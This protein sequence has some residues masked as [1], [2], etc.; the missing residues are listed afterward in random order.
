MGD[1]VGIRNSWD[2]KAFK[3]TKPE[4]CYHE[5]LTWIDQNY[6]QPTKSK[7]NICNT[8]FVLLPLDEYNCIREG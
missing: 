7:C 1:K 5:N 8:V 3:V 6:D 2:D 4:D